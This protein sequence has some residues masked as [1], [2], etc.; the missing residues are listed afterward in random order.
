MQLPDK[1]T[2]VLVVDDEACIRLS[3]EK[4]LAGAGFSVATAHDAE[5]A[6]RKLGEQE[7]HVALVDLV[8]GNGQGGI[9]IIKQI[10]ESQPFCQPILISGYPTFE[11]A[12]ETLKYETFAYLTKPVKKVI[13][14]RKETIYKRV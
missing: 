9:E 10:K 8:L 5:T 14:N 7:F 1:K 13:Y 12:A 6:G 3:M 4:L 11:S 2:K